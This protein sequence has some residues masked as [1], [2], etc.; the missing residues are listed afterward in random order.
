MI[1]TSNEATLHIGKDSLLGKGSYGS[2]HR[3]TIHRKQYDKIDVAC[4]CQDLDDYLHEF[5]IFQFLSQ[6]GGAPRSIVSLLDWCGDENRILIF[7]LYK[8]SLTDCVKKPEYCTSVSFA[9]MV[10]DQLSQAL[11]WLHSKK[12]VSHND[13]SLD[14][15]MLRDDTTVVLIDFGL[16]AC[17]TEEPMSLPL[18]PCE[19][20]FTLKERCQEYGCKTGGYNSIPGRFGCQI[21]ALLRELWHALRIRY[22]LA[23]VP[24]CETSRFKTQKIPAAW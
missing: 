9:K 22:A 6:E 21:T 13:I 10:W 1:T 20:V 15:A 7:P 14:N 12:N 2:V 3:G 5:R 24:C 17:C 8:Y 18:D 11:K 23:M 16:A 19:R 4:K